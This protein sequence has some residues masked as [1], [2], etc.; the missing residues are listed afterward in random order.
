MHYIFGAGRAGTYRVTMSKS[1]RVEGSTTSRKFRGP[2]AR[3]IARLM[4][5]ARVAPL[6][7]RGHAPPLE[8]VRRAH[9]AVTVRW[10]GR[11]NDAEVQMSSNSGDWTRPHHAMAAGGDGALGAEWTS[12]TLTGVELGRKWTLRL[13]T[14]DGETW[15]RWCRPYLSL[16]ASFIGVPVRPSA[17][18]VETPFPR[19]VE[20]SWVDLP[21]GYVAELTTGFQ[22]HALEE[23]ESIDAV[24]SAAE[25]ASLASPPATASAAADAPL[26][27]AAAAASTDTAMAAAVQNPAPMLGVAKRSKKQRAA[28][29]LEWARM[30]GIGEGEVRLTLICNAGA[31]GAGDSRAALLRGLRPA[32]RYR[33]THRVRNAYGWSNWSAP[34]HARTEEQLPVVPPPSPCQLAC[35][36]ASA[37]IGWVVPTDST[38]VLVDNFLL[39]RSMDGT[40]WEDAKRMTP[41]AVTPPWLNSAFF[42]SGKLE[43]APIS[44]NTACFLTQGMDAADAES[45]TLTIPADLGG[46]NAGSYA[47]FRVKSH[48][49]AGW[50]HY[51]APAKLRLAFLKVPAAPPTPTLARSTFFSAHLEFATQE[52]GA[53]T[54]R[55]AE[56]RV[57]FTRARGVWTGETRLPSQTVRAPATS[58]TIEGLLPGS[59][60]WARVRCSNAAGP[61]EWSRPPLVIDTPPLGVG[62]PVAVFAPSP[63]NPSL[64]PEWRLGTVCEAQENSSACVQLVDFP[65]VS[66]R[67]PLSALRDPRTQAVSAGGAALTMRLGLDG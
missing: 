11:F 5:P 24:A 55:P 41:T 67:V 63:W 12:C 30:G 22:L 39:Q 35:S 1:S 4:H 21:T 52:Q 18:V 37:T 44:L 17:L 9:T 61:S 50:S 25:L 10:R 34:V 49:P 64:A 51:S 59:R 58:C 56:R 15:S 31:S 45:R 57:E 28:A 26:S 38:G 16:A 8:L 19:A 43:C 14:F 46:S 32:T 27:A 6:V 23:P 54:S 20:L 60:Y 2:A 36:T 3:T 65:E 66:Y 53:N 33:F 13:R 42:E 29:P 7:E 47:Y 62:D 40:R 48:T